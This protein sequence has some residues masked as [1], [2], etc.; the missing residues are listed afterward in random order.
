[1]NKLI[2]VIVIAH[3]SLMME[4]CT[5][6][7]DA[8]DCPRQPGLM[9]KRIDEVNLIFSEKKEKSISDKSNLNI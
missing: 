5:K 2:G 3:I 1:M 7:S 9:C 6:N 8:F 4:G